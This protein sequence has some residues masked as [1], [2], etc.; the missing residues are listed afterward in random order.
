MELGHGEV[1]LHNPTSLRMLPDPSSGVGR[2]KS[3]Q[4]VVGNLKIGR[5]NLPSAF[6]ELAQ[7][8]EQC[9]GEEPGTIPNLSPKGEVSGSDVR[10]ASAGKPQGLYLQ[11]AHQMCTSKSLHVQASCRKKPLKS[12][13][14]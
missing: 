8:L 7:A 3:E 9:K 2:A 5:L 12:W 13:A 14:V 10:E 4:Q 11:S 6:L 1:T